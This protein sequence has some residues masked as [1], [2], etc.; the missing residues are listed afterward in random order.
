MGTTVEAVHSHLESDP[1]LVDVLLRDVLSLRRA[2]RW[3]IQKHDWETTEEAVV[4]A[5]RRYAEDSESTSIWE[6]RPK[7]DRAEI[8]VRSGL[9]LVTLPRIPEIQ[10][11]AFD[12][13]VE[14]NRTGP[15]ALLWGRTR[16]RLLIEERSVNALSNALSPT[17]LEEVTAP[18][19]AVRLTFPCQQPQ[20][21]LLT[22]A[23]TG[24]AHQG[25]EALEVAS[26]SPEWVIVVPGDYA[27]EAH[28]VLCRLTS[29]DED[30]EPVE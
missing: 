5:L 20:I 30:L 3:L 12:A 28:D 19:S 17:A 23:L 8:D 18:V 26:C 27:L 15:I 7:L 4:S 13:W 10:E 29:Q 24:L 14:A 22:L 1:A 25:I 2:A 21:P 16:T 6:A 11:S 9:A